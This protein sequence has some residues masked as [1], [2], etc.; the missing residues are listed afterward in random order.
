MQKRSSQFKTQLLQL[1]KRGQFQCMKFI[2]SLYHLHVSPFL[3]QQTTLKSS[4]AP[5]WF[6]SSIGQSAVSPA[7]LHFSR[8]PHPPLKKP[9]SL[10]HGVFGTNY[11]MSTMS[12]DLD[13]LTGKQRTMNSLSAY[14]FMQQSVLPLVGPCFHP[15]SPTP[16]RRV[17]RVLYSHVCRSEDF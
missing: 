6:A 4:P 8:L 15:V 14:D 10:P 16:P 12:V 17:P 2:F 11:K 5:N 7:S 1:A 3:M 13:D 9:N